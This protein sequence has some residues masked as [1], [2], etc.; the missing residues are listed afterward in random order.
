M[1][2]R[3]KDAIKALAPKHP[4]AIAGAKTYSVG[5]RVRDAIMGIPSS[6]S[7]FAVTGATPE[8]MTA[9]GFEQ[10]GKD[11]PVFLHP[12]TKDEYALARTER[13]TSGG[14]KGFAV[15]FGR[16]VPIE[17]DLSRRD[18]TVN[19]MAVDQ[20]GNLVDPFNGLGDIANK[21]L[22]MTGPA[23]SED[24]LR[25]FRAARFAASFSFS[26]EPATLAA[27]ESIALSGELS[28][29]PS[30]RVFAEFE[31]SLSKP[32]P[33]SFVKN[34]VDS[35]VAKA[36]LPAILSVASDPS[37][38][39]RMDAASLSYCDNLKTP[40]PAAV[41]AAFCLGAGPAQS[42]ACRELGV[43]REWS[44]LSGVCSA[45]FFSMTT[46]PDP[47]PET[48]LDALCCSDAFRRPERF[49]LALDTL[50]HACRLPAND[51]FT[52]TLA[53]ALAES[54]KIDMGAVASAVSDKSQIPAA[55]RQ[56]RLLAAQAA[57]ADDGLRSDPKPKGAKP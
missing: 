44:D 3:I 1:D 41:W 52:R 5:G 4:V 49:L 9:L 38:L 55:V 11:F 39:F 54:A 29:L 50:R 14:H 43:P 2:E 13:K 16:D 45:L 35:K 8:E 37:S 48:A 57:L 47:T 25:V 19:A 23:F 24:P 36:R 31:K 28:L 42:A 53:G 27:M 6:D 7:D 34:L 26:I 18:L 56:A 12:Q 17:E 10:V 20:D 46:T 22:R 21:T 51:R 32:F 40:D 15:S 33:S 30:E